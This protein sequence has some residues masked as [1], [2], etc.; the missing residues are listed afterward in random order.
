MNAAAA[1]IDADEQPHREA[2]S[3]FFR[4]MVDFLV[5]RH[6]RDGVRARVPERVRRAIETLPPEGCW[7][8]SQNIEEIMRAVM[9]LG[10]PPIVVQMGKFVAKKMSE[11]RL[12]PVISGIYSV[13]GH[14]PAALFRSLNVTSS[15]AIRGM[16]FE[17]AD[18][19]VTVH[20]RGGHVPVAAFHTLRGSLKYIFELTGT[21]GDVGEPEPLT[22]DA[23]GVRVRYRV[24]C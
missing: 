9:E 20:Y 17:Y 10:G 15:L 1:V 11:G 18:D 23:S 16:T 4:A 8:P 22:E 14:S 21:R 19:Y 13:L 7:L 6:L 24:R 12:K 5:A 3:L 2:H